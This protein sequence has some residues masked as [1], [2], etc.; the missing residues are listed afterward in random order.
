MMAM[1]FFII[2][3]L[4]SVSVVLVEEGVSPVPGCTCVEK[5]WRELQRICALVGLFAFRVSAFCYFVADASDVGAPFFEQGLHV[6][7]QRSREIHLLF[8]Q[9]MTEAQ[10][11]G[12]QGLAR[13]ECV[14]VA[15]KVEKFV[16]ICNYLAYSYTLKVSLAP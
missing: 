10:G 2:S 14:A 11:E 16:A 8:G 9:R 3:M 4:Y 13:T 5:A 15:D 12:M 1:F 6:G 7:R